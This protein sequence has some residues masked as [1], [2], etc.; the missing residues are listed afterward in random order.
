MKLDWPEFGL[1]C[2]DDGRLIFVWRRYSRIESN[3]RHC[4][5]V[6]LLPQGPDEL[7]QWVFHLRFPE[8][9]TPGLVVVRVDVPPDRLQEAEEYTDLLRR[10]YGVP[11]HAP[12]AV[13][14][15]GL[16]RVPQEGAEWIATPASDASEE[17]FAAVMARAEGDTG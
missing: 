7:S 10:H 17:L 13:E 12:D 9:P 1:E 2:R 15:T 14:D 11:E 6:R 3:V 4:S 8:G 5:H 16:R